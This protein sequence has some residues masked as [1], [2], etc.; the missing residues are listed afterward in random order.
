M[1]GAARRRSVGF[2]YEGLSDTVCRPLADFPEQPPVELVCQI[3]RGV[4]SEPVSNPACGHRYCRGCIREML[5]SS[6]RCPVGACESVIEED[7]RLVPLPAEL[8]RAQDLVVLCKDRARGCE[9]RGP[10]RQFEEHSLTCKRNLPITCGM[11][12]QR[13][14]RPIMDRHITTDCPKLPAKCE[15]CGWE[16]LAVELSSHLYHDCVSVPPDK[17]PSDP[18]P[19]RGAAAPAAAAPVQKEEPSRPELQPHQPGHS[20]LRPSKPAWADASGSPPTTGLLPRSAAQAASPGAGMLPR[21]A[22]GGGRELD[23]RKIAGR[24]DN[25]DL[26]GL[27]RGS[28]QGQRASPTKQGPIMVMLGQ[29]DDR[30]SSSS[31]AAS[32]S[33][34]PSPKRASDSGMT[35]TRKVPDSPALRSVAAPARRAGGPPGPQQVLVLDSAGAQ[36]PR[37]TSPPPAAG[38]PRP[39]SPQEW[40][41]VEQARG[42]AAASPELVDA[43]LGC[44]LELEGRVRRLE[45][46]RKELRKQLKAAGCSLKRVDSG[47]VSD[48][49]LP[50]DAGT[51]G[52]G[53]GGP[54]AA[55]GKSP[56]GVTPVM[57]SSAR[58]A[59]S[60][61]SPLR[62]RLEGSC[63]PQRS[64]GFSPVLHAAQQAC[65]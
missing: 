17:V 25:G 16:G 24:I 11:C 64:R 41:L 8:R 27:R 3:G 31:D 6:R 36:P 47:G 13:V 52:D 2:S 56:E 54:A 1:P 46:E 10:Q 57:R 33:P 7:A 15:W 21:S 29:G 62:M 53:G 19:Q 40:A 26:K 38:P 50:A 59:H 23:V 18:P 35:T 48:P 37:G 9:W 4:M 34:P 43:L 42:G 45:R 60:S 58:G 20:I 63:S 32:R 44:V 61:G 65:H 55:R 22:A 30:D 5:R 12:K 49:E 28:S 51:A 14:P 39:S